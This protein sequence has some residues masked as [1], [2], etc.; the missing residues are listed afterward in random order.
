MIM[1]IPIQKEGHDFFIDYLKG[2]SILFVV[3][4]HCLPKQEYILFSLWGAQ[5]V[6]LF[7]LIQVFHAYKKGIDKVPL[8]YNLP[9]LFQRI[10]KPFVV[11]LVVEVVL[12][13]IVYK[14][15]IVSVF[16]SAVI[17][18]GIGPGSYYVWIYLQFFFLLPIFA[19]V[20]KR[21]G[22]LNSFF[23]FTFLC[24]LIEIA[25]SYIQPYWFIY[26]LLSIRYL[27]L[28]Y[29]GYLW[30]SDGIVINKNTVFLSVLSIVFILI[31]AYTDWNLEPWFYSNAWKIFHW[32][33]Y[34]YTAYLFIYLFI[35]HY[36]STF[37][38]SGE[39]VLL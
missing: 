36:L 29:L 4:T 15:E 24:I 31:F 9:K 14:Q 27:Y 8:S 39:K 35:V 7:L 34:F 10:L 28:V 1:Y 19:F 20:I 13:V 37:R 32:V 25:C 21:L 2:V 5:A 38:Y 3:L 12:L 18:G 11:L 33:T 23:F 17:S 22:K 16:K 30:V 26:R 6:P